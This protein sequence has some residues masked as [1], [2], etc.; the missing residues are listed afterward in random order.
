MKIDYKKLGLDQKI[1]KEE[2]INN[3]DTI[4]TFSIA[5]ALVKFSE[6]FGIDLADCIIKD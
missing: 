3:I 2:I 1:L 4:L 6:N 5:Y